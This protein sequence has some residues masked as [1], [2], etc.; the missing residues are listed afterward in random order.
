MATPLSVVSIIFP[1]SFLNSWMAFSSPLLM[2]GLGGLIFLRIAFVSPH[3]SS[4]FPWLSC[5]HTLSFWEMYLPTGGLVTT[6][7]LGLW[8]ILSPGLQ[9][10]G[11]WI[12][13]VPTFCPYIPLCSWVVICLWPCCLGYF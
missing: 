4:A 9:L 3:S 11:F 5:W 1:W 10:V 12:S 6:A 13:Y 2:L 7:N 8:P